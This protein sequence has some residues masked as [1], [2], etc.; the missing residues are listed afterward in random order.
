SLLVYAAME[1]DLLGLFVM[2]A[3]GGKSLPLAV[4]GHGHNDGPCWSPDGKMIAYSNGDIWIVDLD[5]EGLRS[6]LRTLN[7][8]TK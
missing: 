8:Q 7:E 3:E 5:P 2:L 1:N 6:E 4:S